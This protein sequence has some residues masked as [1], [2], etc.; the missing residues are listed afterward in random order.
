MDWKSVGKKFI[1][2]GLPLLGTIVGGPLGGVA[3]KAASA[4]IASKLGCEEKELNPDMLANALADPDTL[5]TLKELE[6]S[7]QLELE[8]LIIQDRASARQREIEITKITG[9]RDI[10]LYILAYL[11]V[12]GF[13]LT[14]IAMSWLLILGKIPDDIPQGAVMLLGMLFGTLTAGVGAIIQYFFGSSKSSNE[15]TQLLAQKQ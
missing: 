7:H 1:Q 12:F 14:T 9:K 3:G 4:L 10:N 11:F 15:K 2:A 13:F 6:L 5:V 8:S